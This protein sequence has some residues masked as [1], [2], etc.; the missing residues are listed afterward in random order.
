ME[1]STVIE[2][3]RCKRSVLS[4]KDKR[5]SKHRFTWLLHVT[6]EH[7]DPNDES[8]VFRLRF[9]TRKAALKAKRVISALFA[10]GRTHKEVWNWCFEAEHIT[11]EFVNK[12]YVWDE[13]E[14]DGEPTRHEIVREK[15]YAARR[16]KSVDELNMEMHQAVSELSKN[17]SHRYALVKVIALHELGANHNSV[18][19]NG[20]AVKEVAA[21]V[22][23]NLV[24]NFLSKL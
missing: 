10:Q 12:D 22:G 6:T 3:Q 17:D 1:D 2:L 9:G 4:N 23:N 20:E 16:C 15:W 14:L 8:P 11:R 13:Y 19:E 21:K 7:V 24:L 18:N 5:G